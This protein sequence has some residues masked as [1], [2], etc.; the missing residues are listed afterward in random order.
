MRYFY[1]FWALVFIGIMAVDMT[2]YPELVENNE[3]LIIYASLTI[4]F[5]AVFHILDAIHKVKKLLKQ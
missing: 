1:T 4:F 2:F 3:E 5:L